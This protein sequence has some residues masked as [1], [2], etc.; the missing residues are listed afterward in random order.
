MAAEPKACQMG[1]YV[2]P[3]IAALI[4]KVCQRENISNSGYLRALIIADLLGRNLLTLELMGN[5]MTG[6]S[7]RQIMEHQT[8][9][10]AS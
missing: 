5:I 2:E 3:S 7:L 10:A 6:A 9:E 4:G 8:V 1:V